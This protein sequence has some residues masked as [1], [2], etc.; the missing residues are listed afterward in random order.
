[1][2]VNNFNMDATGPL[3]GI[4]FGIITFLVFLF[5]DRVNGEAVKIHNYLAS[6]RWHLFQ[7]PTT[8]KRINAML[9][10]SCYI[11]F[12]MPPIT[13]IFWGSG[14]LRREK[15]DN[16]DYAGGIAVFLVGF[17]LLFFLY[18]VFLIKW[19]KYRV[20]K[21]AAAFMAI[22]WLL[23]TAYEITT[24]FVKGNVSFFA[25][26]VI[27]LTPNGVILILVAFLAGRKEGAA[28]SEIVQALPEGEVLDVK[29][30]VTYEDEITKAYEFD[31][32]IPTQNEIFEMFTLNKAKDVGKIMGPFEGGLLKMFYKM[33]KIKR[34]LIVLTLYFI[35][36]VILGIYAML[37]Y[38]VRNHSGLG[39]ITMCTVIATDFIIYLYNQSDCVVNPAEISVHIMLFRLLLFICGGDYWIYGYCILYLYF[40]IYIGYKIA[41]L[42]FPFMDEMIEEELEAQAKDTEEKRNTLDLAKTPEFIFILVTCLFM[43]LLALFKALPESSHIPLPSLQVGNKKFEYWVYGVFSILFVAISF[44]SILTFRTYV[45][46]KNGIDGKVFVYVHSKPIDLSWFFVGITYCLL[47][48]VAVVA[49]WISWDKRALVVGIMGPATLIAMGN[50]YLRFAQNDYHYFQN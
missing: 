3:L 33:S 6:R 50:A 35:S 47:C 2:G 13:L 8:V 38:L 22:S 24:V 37:D 41:V 14:L 34:I 25:I 15:K 39:I 7:S 4:F 30:E 11:F 43:F 48:I 45:R 16:A 40:G 36:L 46:K 18:G 31:E 23:L 1:M 5:L 20:T 49:W 9:V 12:S 19:N 44:F 32:Y 21:L 28:V 29:R 10:V 26:S 17:S 42:R 27:F